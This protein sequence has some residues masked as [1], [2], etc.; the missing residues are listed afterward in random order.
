MDDNSG[1]KNWKEEIEVAGSELINR[2]KTLV[3]EGNVRRLIIKN[4]K[5]DV[6]LEIPLTAGVAV[7]GI[8]A[9]LAPVLAAIGA[10]AGLLTKVKIEI[11]RIDKDENE[12][13]I[14]TGNVPI[15]FP[16]EPLH[17]KWVTKTGFK[18]SKDK[19]V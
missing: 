1:K 12:T 10:I 9:L 18:S 5:G 17:G 2:I 11:V 14:S 19:D 15:L 3:K 8:V 7:G 4:E 16:K 6:L 13:S